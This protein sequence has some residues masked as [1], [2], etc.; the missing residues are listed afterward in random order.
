MIIQNPSNGGNACPNPENENCNHCKFNWAEWG[1][2][3]GKRRMREATIITPESKGGNKCPAPE[4]Q[5]C[6]HCAFEWAEWGVCDGVTRSRTAVVQT[7]PSNGGNECPGEDTQNCQ[8]CKMD[9][10][11]QWGHCM[12]GTGVVKRTRQVKVSSIHG[13]KACPNGEETKQCNWSE[14]MCFTACWLS[15]D[16]SV[17]FKNVK[18]V[19]PYSLLVGPVDTKMCGGNVSDP[20]P[21][22]C[23]HGNEVVQGSSAYF[24]NVVRHNLN[25]SIARDGLPRVKAGVLTMLFVTDHLGYSSLSFFYGRNKGDRKRTFVDL[26]SQASAFTQVDSY[27]DSSS[28]VSLE[29]NQGSDLCSR[30]RLSFD[31]KQSVMSKGFS[32]YSLGN[33]EANDCVDI[34]VQESPDLLEI[35]SPDG[36]TEVSK[37]GAKYGLRLC[38]TST[39]RAKLDPEPV[40]PNPRFF[41]DAQIRA[42]GDYGPREVKAMLAERL[43]V[44]SR[45]RISV[46]AIDEKTR[47]YSVRFFEKQ[48]TISNE[49]DLGSVKSNLKDLNTDPNAELF[50]DKILHESSENGETEKDPDGGYF[51]T[52]IRETGGDT[53]LVDRVDTAVNSS[54]GEEGILSLPVI[55]GGVIGGALLMILAVA[56]IAR[57]RNARNGNKSSE[58][59]K[60]Q[61]IAK[62]TEMHSYNSA[63]F[64]GTERDNSQV[65]TGSWTKHYDSASGRF[66][67]S[68]GVNTTWG[69]VK[70]HGYSHSAMI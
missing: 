59:T 27:S 16:R 26:V 9:E 35:V 17:D 57:M 60:G 34:T 20:L 58:T 14:N 10:W 52:T 30:A 61:G 33:F 3:D 7:G 22:T 25:T 70:Y 42:S 40:C 23:N 24:R 63:Y 51:K 55:I 48:G 13:G 54:G 36:I 11:G 44:S 4:Y 28:S 1:T 31:P 12:P 62:E 39:C 15:Q 65:S 49:P 37:E 69:D 6:N 68:D 21:Q 53:V 5:P 45:N 32:G 2:C 8:D 18:N 29:C 19:R 67:F 46:S 41:F 66:F 43:G 56:L 47:T 64:Y 50:F 38:A